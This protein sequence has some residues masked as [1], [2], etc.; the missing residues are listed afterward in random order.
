MTYSYREQKKRRNTRLNTTPRWRSLGHARGLSWLARNWC[1]RQGRSGCEGCRTT[2]Y[3]K[4]SSTRLVDS[5]AASFEGNVAV[6]I[7]GNADSGS[8]AR[9]E[10]LGRHGAEPVARYSPVRTTA[11]DASRRYAFSAPSNRFPYSEGGDQA[12]EMDELAGHGEV[13]PHSSGGAC[14][15]TWL[16]L[17]RIWPDMAVVAPCRPGASPRYGATRTS[18]T[19]GCLGPHRFSSGPHATRSNRRLTAGG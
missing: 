8:G 17:S 9:V 13:A 15:P 10:E 11:R 14:R 4:M 1:W 12:S 19:A 7:W 16:L 3:R 6:D 5:V 18:T 2:G